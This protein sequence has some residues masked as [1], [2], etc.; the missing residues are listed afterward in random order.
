LRAFPR[1]SRRVAGTFGPWLRSSSESG[2]SHNVVGTW[3]LAVGSSAIAVAFWLYHRQR[4]T[5][6]Q[7]LE[8]GPVSETPVPDPVNPM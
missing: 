4:S 5:G 2:Q 8:S 3:V 1:P 7:L 6:A